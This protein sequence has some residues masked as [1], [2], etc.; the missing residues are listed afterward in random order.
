MNSEEKKKSGNKSVDCPPSSGEWT[1]EDMENA[2]P[3]GLPEIA[4]DD[5]DGDGEGATQKKPTTED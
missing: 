1:L 3:M 2:E 5:M 4:E